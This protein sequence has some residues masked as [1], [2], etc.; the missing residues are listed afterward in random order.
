MSTRESLLKFSQQAQALEAQVQALIAEFRPFIENHDWEELYFAESDLYDAADCLHD[1][2]D[3]CQEIV[4]K[5]P[6]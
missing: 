2:S 3:T 1:V 5:L 4:T 6:V